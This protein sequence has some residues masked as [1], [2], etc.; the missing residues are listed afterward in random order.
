MMFGQIEEER[1][2]K[3]IDLY[4]H[5]VNINYLI[6]KNNVS[7]ISVYL[8]LRNFNK[9]NNHCINELSNKILAA[10]R[11]QGF[12]I[13]LVKTRR[14]PISNELWSIKFDCNYSIILRSSSNTDFSS[15]SFQ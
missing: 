2:V 13:S 8:D 3:E 7:N 10:A 12:K 1:M 6:W 15:T 4:Y 11:I 9:N 5:M 14:T